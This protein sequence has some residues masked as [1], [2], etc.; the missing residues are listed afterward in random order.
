MGDKIQ[1]KKKK[2]KFKRNNKETA[3]KQATENQIAA[4]VA[5]E[6]D[7]REASEGHAY[8]LKT[9]SCFLFVVFVCRLR[10][11]RSYFKIIVE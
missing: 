6:T 9:T 11:L 1:Q 3:V 8:I 4:V 5:V 7:N 10:L 2:Q